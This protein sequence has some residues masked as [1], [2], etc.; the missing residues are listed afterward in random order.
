MHLLTRLAARL[1]QARPGR[2]TAR[3]PRGPNGAGSDRRPGPGRGSLPEL[4]RAA[5]KPDQ[6]TWLVARAVS[7]RAF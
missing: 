3:E 7:L 4:A 1:H 6:A 5:L 2:A